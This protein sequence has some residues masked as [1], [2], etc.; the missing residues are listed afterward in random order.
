VSKQSNKTWFNYTPL[1]TV[2][3]EI[4]DDGTRVLRSIPIERREEGLPPLELAIISDETKLDLIR[5]GTPNSDGNLSEQ[6]V[7]QIGNIMDHATALNRSKRCAN[8]S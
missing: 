2:W 3:P 4:K 7:H 5:V 1:S 6:E 8:R